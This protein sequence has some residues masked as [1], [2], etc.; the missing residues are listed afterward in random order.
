VLFQS[1]AP[2]TLRGYDGYWRQY[3][4]HCA[5]TGKDPFAEDIDNLSAWL[6]LRITNGVGE[7]ST[8][9]ASAA[10]RGTW[11]LM[12]DAFTRLD[13][14]GMAAAKLNRPKQKSNEEIWELHYVFDYCNRPLLELK[15]MDLKQATQHAIVLLK[16]NTGWRSA[17]LAAITVD[18]GLFELED[19]KGYRVRAWNTKTFKNKW[20]PWVQLHRLYSPY[21]AFCPCAAIENM[22]GLQTLPIDP[23]SLIHVRNQDNKTMPDAPLFCFQ[24]AKGKLRKPLQHSTI[25]NYFRDYF[26]VNVT[27]KH[28]CSLDKYYKSHSSRHAVATMLHAMGVSFT[29]ISRLTLNSANTL[30]SKYFRRL[31][32]TDWDLQLNCCNKVQ[33]LSAK[34]LVPIVHHLSSS[35]NSS[36]KCSCHDFF[37]A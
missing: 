17:D 21:A 34:L 37:H 19:G 35:S 36:G 14:M 5:T 25:A 4:L 9:I 10:I 22:R 27:G 20:T 16:A 3:K 29:D 30:E 2:S 23:D 18:C 24:S 26:L 15:Q 1:W 13:K 32:S 33:N 7:G 12:T 8:E 28:G 31:E 11:A 6:A